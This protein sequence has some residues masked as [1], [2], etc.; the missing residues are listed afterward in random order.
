MSLPSSGIASRMTSEAFA[1]VMR[2]CNA[3]FCPVIIAVAASLP[4]GVNEVRRF[5]AA[6]NRHDKF[7]FL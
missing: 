6:V 2:E 5:L 7:P 1:I 3:D 4:D